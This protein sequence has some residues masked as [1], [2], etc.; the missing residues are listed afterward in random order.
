MSS[1]NWCLIESD[2]GAPGPPASLP[3]V[4]VLPLPPTEHVQ[5]LADTTHCRLVPAGVFTELVNRMGVEDAQV[6]ELLDMDMLPSM[7][8]VSLLPPPKAKT[9]TCPPSHGKLAISPSTPRGLLYTDVG[10]R[11]VHGLIFLFKYS[12]K[13]EADPCVEHDVPGLFFAHQV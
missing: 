8:C 11:P 12:G 5:L 10:C 3:L 4:A 7:Q 13:V 1:G 9:P 2:P 6:D